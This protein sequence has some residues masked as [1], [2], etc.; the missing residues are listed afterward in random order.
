METKT[1]HFSI[2]GEWLTDFIRQGWSEG[3]YEWAMETLKHSG[4]P[5][6]YHNE[7]LRGNL[8]MVGVNEFR[9]MEDDWRPTLSDCH[10]GTYPDPSEIFAMASDGENYKKLYFQRLGTD[11]YATKQRWDQYP[12]NRANL[13]YYIRTFPEEFVSTLPARDREMWAIATGREELHYG[14]IDE[15][16]QDNALKV[17]RFGIQVPTV[18]EFIERARRLEKKEQPRPDRGCISNFGWILPNGDF[19]PC[20]Y[21]EHDWLVGTFD[22]T[23][24]QAENEGWIRVGYSQVTGEQ[25]ITR[26]N[27][28]REITQGQIDS[29]NVWCLEHDF[30]IPEWVKENDDWYEWVKG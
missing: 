7:V 30:D 8:K 13:Q 26:G 28:K 29:V 19:Y 14:D 1:V 20:L 16:L 9:L 23:V 3:R 5:S 22:K 4:C 21:W 25:Y 27:P 17:A 24:T 12:S 15:R 2:E 10:F 6:E 18:D 11:Y